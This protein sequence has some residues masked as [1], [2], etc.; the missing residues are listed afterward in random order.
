MNFITIII[1]AVVVIL[2]AKLVFHASVKTLIKLVI[3]TLLGALILWLINKFGASIGLNV[4][5]N[6]ITALVVGI[7][8]VP[9]VILLVLLSLLGVF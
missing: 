2:L 7:F 8:G 9:G 5:L 3:N 6:L 1:T 4:P